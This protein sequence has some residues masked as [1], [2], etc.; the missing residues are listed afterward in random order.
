[1]NEKVICT[2]SDTD[3]FPARHKIVSTGYFY[4]KYNKEF[5][6]RP[7]NVRFQLGTLDARPN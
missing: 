5:S 1:M 6:Q 4:V 7:C 3:I 2:L